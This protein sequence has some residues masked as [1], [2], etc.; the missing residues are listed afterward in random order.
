MATRRNA[1][2]TAIETYKNSAPK[3]L[4]ACSAEEA[5]AL[6][7]ET[8]LPH[9]DVLRVE[10]WKIPLPSFCKDGDFGVQGYSQYENLELQLQTAYCRDR[11]DDVRGDLVKKANLY[12]DEVRG[13]TTQ[14]E[15]TRGGKKLVAAKKH[16]KY[17]QT[18]YK[19]LVKR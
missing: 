1:I 2:E 17:L 14:S 9:G 15:I 16:L 5:I 13:N 8:P 18:A 19:L 12:R 7:N 10:H 11:L 3:F 6:G 4:A